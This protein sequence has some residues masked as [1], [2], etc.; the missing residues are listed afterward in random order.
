MSQE[1][2]AT[3]IR[4]YLIYGD[5]DPEAETYLT[6]IRGSYIRPLPCCNDEMKN[7]LYHNTTNLRIDHLPIFVCA[8]GSQRWLL[9]WDQLLLARTLAR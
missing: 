4:V 2:M 8:Q 7:L 1:A 5:A 3:S 6:A 9:N